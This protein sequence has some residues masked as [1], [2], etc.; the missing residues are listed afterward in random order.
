MRVQRAFA[1]SQKNAQELLDVAEGIGDIRK[2]LVNNQID[3]VELKERL[4][5]GIGTPLHQIAETLFPELEQRLD[6]FQKAL[7]ETR[8]PIA[9]HEAARL[10]TE[11]ILLAMQKVLS[12]MIEMEDYNQ[13]VEL[14]REIIKLQDQLDKETQERH[15]QK[16]RE[17]LEE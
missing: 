8:D 4:E 6:A 15:K 5:Q 12:R 10:Q 1:N 17:M 3:T 9:L 11:T 2:Q 7:E 14:L 13:A 16:L